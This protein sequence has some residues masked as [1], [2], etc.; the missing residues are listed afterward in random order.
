MQDTE[1]FME[2]AGIA[3]VF[4]GFGALISIRSGGASEPHEVAYIRSIVSVAVWVV[5][6]ALA[7]VTFGRYGL[8]GHDLWL[9]CSVLA[10]VLLPVVWIANSRT[11]EMRQ[12]Y[13]RARLMRGGAIN[14]FLLLSLLVALFL[15][16]LGLVPDQ[17]PALYLTAG[18]LGLLGT[19]LT[20]LFL[21]FSQRRPQM[22]SDPAALPATGGSNP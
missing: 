20:L 21:V 15:V 6:V 2:L 7:P 4:V 17:E 22:A 3:G 1:L 11:P 16:A 12:E 14:A 18:E 13:A 19:A 9:A 5:V 8:A 10:L